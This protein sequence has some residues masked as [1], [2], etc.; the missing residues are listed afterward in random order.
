MNDAK[1]YKLQSK[2]LTNEIQKRLKEY[3]NRLYKDDLID[4]PTFK[5]LSS[6]SDP[7]AVRFYILPKIHKQGNPGRPIISSNGHPTERIS[8]FV[9]FHL[10]PLV[11]MLPSYIKDTTHFLLQLQNLGPLPDNAI[12]VTLDVSSLYTNI[13]HKEGI[14]ACRHF[15]NTRQNKSLPTERICDLIRMILTMNNFTFNDQHFLQIR[16]TAMGTRMAPS[17]ANLFMGKF[18]QAIENAT[19]KSFVWRRFIDDIFMV[20]TEGEEHLKTFISYLNSIQPTIK[21][22]HEYSSSRNQTLPFLDVQVHLHNN[23]I[24]TDLH[25]KPTD[26]HQYLLKSSCHPNHTERTIPFSLALRLRRICST[27]T[28]FDQRCKEL[29]AYL[30]KRGYNQSFLTKEIN[31]VRCIPRHETLKPREENSNANRVPFDIT[32]NPALPNPASTVRKHLGILQ[33]SNHCKQTFSSPPVL[34]YKRSASLRDLLVLTRLRDPKN[35]DQR[36]TAGIY[37]CKYPRCLTC[38]FLQ[39]GQDKYIFFSTNEE[40]RIKDTLTC[41]SKNLIYLIE[42]KKCATR[43]LPCLAN[44]LGRLNDIFTNALA[45]IVVPSKIINSL[46]TQPLFR[47][48]STYPGTPSTTSVPF[49]WN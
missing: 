3:I 22:T 44:T 21:F 5:Y 31:R 25:T 30:V 15:L 34:A 14:E 33:S 13:P 32:F 12:L 4:E 26:K 37:R 42:R 48:I 16:G 45:N 6:N 43:N 18:E 1:F 46:L 7:Q 27:D 39:H 38:P 40:R 35:K 2:D 49:P 29:I 17:Y 11:Q 24:Q 23:E 36:S 41:K 28:F 9:D 10:K 20:W 8:Q 19:Y 47:N